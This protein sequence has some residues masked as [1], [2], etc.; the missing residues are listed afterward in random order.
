MIKEETESQDEEEQNNI[1]QASSCD[2]SLSQ[3]KDEPKNSFVKDEEDSEEDDVPLVNRYLFTNMKNSCLK[4]IPKY[5]NKFNLFRGN[6]SATNTNWYVIILRLISDVLCG[7]FINFSLKLHN[8][9]KSSIL[10]M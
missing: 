7:K 6:P 10:N 8:L 5:V 4:L 2:Y 1:S 3:F 9:K